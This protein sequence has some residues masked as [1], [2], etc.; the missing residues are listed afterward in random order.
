MNRKPLILGA[1]LAATLIA[2]A[3]AAAERA[4][5]SRATLE[6]TEAAEAV[7]VG[8]VRGKAHFVHGRRRDKVSLH[9]RGLEA[10]QAYLWHVHQAVADGDPCTDSDVGNPAP[11]PG[12]EYR[13]LTAR[14]SGNAGSKGTSTSF[15]VEDED[16]GEAYYVNVHLRDGTVIAC[17]VP[18][19]R[20][21]RGADDDENGENQRRGHRES[22]GRGHE[23]HGQGRG[24]G[25]GHDEDDD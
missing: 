3:T 16:T 18:E 10:G 8:D 11:Y 1:A 15:P 25:R 22:R 21:A 9:V 14:D 7:G 23:E 13:E 2:P 17:G 4:G 24:R 20:R 12:F 5:V 6:A 19:D